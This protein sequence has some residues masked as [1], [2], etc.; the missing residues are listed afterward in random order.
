[1]V[2][3]VAKKDGLFPRM[4]KIA[5]SANSLAHADGTVV[6]HVGCGVT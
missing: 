2:V 1:M 5:A 4:A 3:L 6:G